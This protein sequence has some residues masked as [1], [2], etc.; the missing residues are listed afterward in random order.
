M[1]LTL[2]LQMWGCGREAEP[3]SRG[4]VP[5]EVTASFRQDGVI[6]TKQAEMTA[7]EIRQLSDYFR[8]NP[9]VA[10]NALVAGDPVIYGTERSVRRFYWCA[11]AIEDVEW[12]C[13]EIDRGRGRMFDGRGNP[14]GNAT[15]RPANP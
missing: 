7:A 1:L 15:E 13:I 2:L 6:W 11:A 5:L 12:L 4:A 8:R 3:L 10:E 14:F 9:S